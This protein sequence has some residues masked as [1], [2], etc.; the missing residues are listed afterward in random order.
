M[1]YAW[2][3]PLSAFLVQPSGTGSALMDGAFCY[4]RKMHMAD[5]VWKI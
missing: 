5:E 4:S 3:S 2:Y 1:L